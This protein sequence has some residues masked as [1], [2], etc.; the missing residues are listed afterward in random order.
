MS[1]L[2]PKTG[3]IPQYSKFHLFCRLA[4][5]LFFHADLA[6]SSDSLTT[7][8]C[9][10]HGGCRSLGCERL[11]ACD[12]RHQPDARWAQSTT[13]SRRPD[14]SRLP[15][16]QLEGVAGRGRAE[17]SGVDAGRRLGDGDER[18][19]FGALEVDGGPP[20]RAW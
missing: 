20:R 4:L 10:T 12:P 14:E 3:Y 8:V 6:K 16:L 1:P 7:S 9:H 19:V 13:L 18:V 2:Q 15:P 17:P 11:R 5:P